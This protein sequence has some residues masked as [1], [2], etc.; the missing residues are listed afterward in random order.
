MTTPYYTSPD[1]EVTLYHGDCREVLPALGLQADL[2]LADPP[3]AETSLAWDRWP[4]G[5]VQVA[6]AHAPAMWCF[7]SQSMF[8]KHLAEFTDDWRLSQ[9]VIGHDDE[10]PVYGDVNI[11]WE[12]HNGTGFAND[13][14]KRVH[15][16]VLHWYRGPWGDVAHDTPRERVYDPSDKYERRNVKAGID[17][18]GKI[19]PHNHVRDGTR[20]IRSVIKAKSVRGQGRNETEKPLP[21]LDPLIRYG[22]PPGGLVLDVFSG[23]GSALEAA[24]MSGRRAIGIELRESQ[25]EAAARRLDQLTLFGT[26][27]A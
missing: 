1:G 22:C 7:G 13:R 27:P 3:Y 4:E 25:C 8:F 2:I 14:F 5:W 21:I 11:V 15:E 9:D 24:R 6:A 18:T 10:G 20:L 16:H 23:S 26:T 12:K 17:H 19:G